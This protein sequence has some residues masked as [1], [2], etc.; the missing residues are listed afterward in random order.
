[1]IEPIKATLQEF[2]LN[3]NSISQF[4]DDYFK[5]CSQLRAI[6][7]FDNNLTYLPDLFWVE[8]SIREIH[9]P[10]NRI[11]SLA[12]VLGDGYYDVLS[13]IDVSHNIINYL[14][15]SSLRICPKLV[16]LF[17]NGNQLTSI[18]DYRAYLSF[19]S[20]VMYSNPWLCDS[21]LAWMSGLVSSGLICHSPGCF[22]G[23]LVTDISEN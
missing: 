8:S 23:Q 13:Y 14:N 18:G 17:V 9:I 5:D 15:I 10:Q 2:S 3:H 12:A 22:A 7:L 6:R 11:Q 1:M 16:W 4:S 21:E 20:L 19:E